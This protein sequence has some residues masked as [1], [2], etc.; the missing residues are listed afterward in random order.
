M[1]CLASVIWKE[2]NTSSVEW[3][4]DTSDEATGRSISGLRGYPGSPPPRLDAYAILH[5]SKN[6]PTFKKFEELA[7]SPI[8]NTLSLQTMAPNNTGQ[9]GSQLNQLKQSLKKYGLSRVNSKGSFNSN[10]KNKS[11]ISSK[12][13]DPEFRQKK[14]AEIHTSQNVFDTK[15][16]KVKFPTSNQLQRQGSNVSKLNQKN[17]A[18][19]TVGKPSQSATQAHRRRE[20]KLLPEYL[21]R[22]K[23]SQFLDKRFGEGDST[24]T[25]EEK[26]L[27][28][29][30]KERQDRSSRTKKRNVFNLDDEGEG[31]YDEDDNAPLTHG[32]LDLNLDDDDDDPA[33]DDRDQPESIFTK[34]Q[35]T[36]RANRSDLD[37][38]EEEHPTKKKTKA[39]VMSEI[40][41]KSKTHKYQRQIMKEKDD[42][43]RDNLND[44]LNEIR[45][46]LLSSQPPASSSSHKKKY[47]SLPSQ[48]VEE[49]EDT[50]ATE[51]ST[52]SGVD[53]ALL[54]TLIGSSSRS[55][56]PAESRDDE[57]DAYDRFVRELAFD[58]RA[59][60]SDR[61]KTG[62]EAA[63][64]E[65]E[66]LRQLEMQRL[67]RM[68]GEDD[69]DDEDEEA[70]SKNKKNRKRKPEADDLEDD[71]FPLEDTQETQW[72]LGDGLR[73]DGAFGAGADAEDESEEETD[74]STSFE[75]G[76]D[77][78]EEADDDPERALEKIQS[79]ISTESGSKNLKASGSSKAELAYTYPC[80][81]SHAEFLS[82]LSSASV[83]SSDLPTVVERIRV[84]HHPSLGEGNKEKLAIFTDVLIDHL[85]YISSQ[86]LPPGT[87]FSDATNG[88]LP[89]IISLCKSYTQ[90]AASHFVSK[91]VLMQ[92]NLT[93]ALTHP[94]ISGWPGASELILFRVI[95]LLWSTSD[96]SHPV[97]A[98]ALLLMNQYLH[99]LR[100]KEF[101]D[102]M[103]GLFLCTLIL[104]YETHSKRFVPEVINFLVLAVLRMTQT[105]QTISQIK[106]L[107]PILEGSQLTFFPIHQKKMGNME[108]QTLDFTGLFGKTAS[109]E[110]REPSDQ[111]L[112][113]AFDVIISLLNNFSDLYGSLNLYPEVF[114]SVLV[115]LESID[116]RN[117]TEETKTRITELI[118]SIRTKIE[119]LN[120]IRSL[121]PI[122][123]Q[124]HKPIPIKSQTPQFDSQF[125]PNQR[126]F[127]PDSNQVEVDK[128]KNLIKKE[129][130][131]A[132][133]ELRKDNR[134][135]AAAQAKEKDLA[136]A[137]YKT[138]IAR[139]TA[140]L[141]EERSEEKK[142]DRL[143]IRLKKADKAKRGK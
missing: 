115:V 63:L 91:L 97:A 72:S 98:P 122:K 51:D 40:I 80:P 58:A 49:D 54:E 114:S 129:K 126:K 39:E 22:H 93:H 25:P 11:S 118:G 28:R 137:Q 55:S 103:S 9:K 95:G 60:P 62:E 56:S 131:G 99:Q 37:S 45:S 10:N 140:S 134:F 133:R 66:R 3:L 15:T 90:T 64:E 101:A 32:G 130:K 65:A 27:E 119:T 48:A 136:D 92:K 41:T 100:V 71:F 120:R 21:N 94:N 17:K 106:C 8:P 124:S 79:L 109:E 31:L 50:E 123:L 125:N 69:D 135:L 12:L 18:I 138:K 86:P 139:I 4:P 70:P 29:F 78:D 47:L 1:F 113:D 112:V 61:L 24:L 43:L 110:A 143:K 52:G 35:D 111:D 81:S 68:R 142:L 57:E 14:L 38:D 6:L 44:D 84:L 34:R 96:F 127:N 77:D 67:K 53:R 89:H 116:L 121:N 20:E 73:P 2:L 85:I 23:S 107:I 16:S 30:T 108:P 88:L 132:I 117:I 42:Q 26:A 46:L 128:L 7:Y 5:I 33:A 141:Q 82:S 74:D 75:S 19:K 105:N 87:S 104:Q 13:K 76:S 83:Q 36:D 102:L 59:M